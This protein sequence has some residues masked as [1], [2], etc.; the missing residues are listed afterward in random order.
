MPSHGSAR[1]AAYGLAVILT[2]CGGGDTPVTDGVRTTVDT[3]GGVTR[4]HNAGAAPVRSLAPVFA[5]GEVG[6]LEEGSVEEFGRVAA[7]LL[8]PLGELYVG[9]THARRIAVFDSTGALLRVMG[10]R[11]AGPGEIEGLQ[12]LGWLADTLVVMDGPNARLTR[13]SRN[14]E[15]GGQWPF[16][17]VSGTGV[18]LYNA[19]VGELYSFAL[20]FSREGGGGGGSEPVWARF[21]P[22]GSSDTIPRVIP[23][24]VARTEGAFELCRAA[25]GLSVF[26]NPLGESVVVRPA[27]DG[28]QAL[29]WTSSY[30]VAFVDA[31]GDTLR[32]LTRDVAPVPV[33]DA[34]WETVAADYADWRATWGGADCEGS[35]ARPGTKRL[36][37]ALHYDARGRLIVEYE[38]RAGRALDFYDDAGRWM[39]TAP[40]V[41]R[42]ESVDPAFRNGRVAVV[43]R[44]SLDVQRVEVF[45][46][47]DGEQ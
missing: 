2:A 23:G 11:G 45:R 10:R 15:Y 24:Q 17:R 33:S 20:R 4:V 8:G 7:V 21:L 31:A 5:V 36:L 38:D 47:A 9:D 42:D 40:F 30:R 35:I 3:T 46:I 16:M 18:R 32:A 14:G 41:E 27:R 28:A 44:D 39:A 37:L 34:E 13:L 25:N 1:P 6:S 12:D 29:A 22:G 19:G 43:R 26:S